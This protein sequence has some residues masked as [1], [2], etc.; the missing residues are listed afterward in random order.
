[1]RFDHVQLVF[2]KEAVLV[3]PAFA[4]AAF[5]R[6]QTEQAGQRPVADLARDQRILEAK[7]LRLLAD[8]GQL[9]SFEV[10]LVVRVG[11]VDLELAHVL[12]ALCVDAFAVLVPAAVAGF[13]VDPAASCA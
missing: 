8:H 6:V 11:L 13:E 7:E 4:E 10:V 2:V 9:A 5:D 1:M 3:R 12:P